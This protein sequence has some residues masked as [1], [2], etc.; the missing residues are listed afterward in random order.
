MI[1]TISTFSSVSCNLHHISVWLICRFSSCSFPTHF[2]VE[3]ATIWFSFST[4]SWNSSA[5]PKYCCRIVDQCASFIF[6]RMRLDTS[7]EGVNYCLQTTSLILYVFRAALLP[8]LLEFFLGFLLIETMMRVSI[9][10]QRLSTTF[11]FDHFRTFKYWN[12]L[13][14]FETRLATVFQIWSGGK[15]RLWKLFDWMKV[16]LQVSGLLSYSKME[17]TLQPLLNFN[18]HKHKGW[19]DALEKLC[20]K[21]TAQI[22]PFHSPCQMR[23]T[24]WLST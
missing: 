17:P 2:Q 5:Q 1:W 20:R 18:S 8:M 11:K 10:R 23:Y 4:C 24:R 13:W 6:C 15:T 12:G 21:R 19:L 22:G 3:Q 7:E 14:C 16:S 9:Y